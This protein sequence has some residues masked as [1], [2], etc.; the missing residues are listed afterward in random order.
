[1]TALSFLPYRVGLI[2]FPDCVEFGEKLHFV[3]LLQ[4]GSHTFSPLIPTTWAEPFSA[5]L[6]MVLLPPPVVVATERYANEANV[7]CE[8]YPTLPRR[9]WNK[10]LYFLFSSKQ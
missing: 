3:Q 1:M 6:Y 9:A 8:D 4:A 10:F 5:A 7:A 2:G